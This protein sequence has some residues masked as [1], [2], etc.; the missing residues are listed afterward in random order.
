[1]AHLFTFTSGPFD[2]GSERKNPINPIAGEGLL[3][4]L[5]AQLDRQAFSVTEPDAEDWGWY[6][7]VVSGQRKYLLGASGEWGERGTRS[8]WTIQLHLKRSLWDRL[9]GTNK[10][11]ANDALSIA[12]EAAVKHNPEFRDVDVD[13]GA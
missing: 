9:S 12:I 5:S 10:L 11:A 7:D 2:P 3:K 6:V 8:Y 1:M 4:W 13:R